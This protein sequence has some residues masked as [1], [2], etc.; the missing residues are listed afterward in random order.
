MSYIR[1]GFPSAEELAIPD[2][3]TRQKLL[4]MKVMG[5]SEEDICAA[6][7]LHKFTVRSYNLEKVSDHTF[8]GQQYEGYY[9]KY[10]KCRYLSDEEIDAIVTRV[11]NG[12]SYTSIAKSEGISSE[13]VAK[14]A[15]EQNVQSRHTSSPL[16]EDEIYRIRIK[17]ENGESPKKIAQEFNR[18]TYSIMEYTKDLRGKVLQQFNKG[19]RT[20]KGD[21]IFRN[22]VKKLR[23]QG[24]KGKEIAEKL[25]CSV[26][27]VYRNIPKSLKRKGNYVK[28][29]SEDDVKV[30]V[31]MRLDGYRVNEVAEIFGV[32][33]NSVLHHTTVPLK[34]I[35][36]LA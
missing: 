27:T 21:D 36:D 18:S 19:L 20:S 13:M 12:E 31:Q 32:V 28:K 3:K 24:F 33:K 4:E 15:T 16:G 7:N 8:S 2:K 11:Q 29:I 17:Y 9:L 14:Y 26:S 35:L 23:E 10:K 6:L 5:F 1:S 25:D 30:M 34:E 22:K